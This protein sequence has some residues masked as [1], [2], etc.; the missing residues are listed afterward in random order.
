MSAVGPM[1]QRITF[2]RKT[3][4]PNSAGDAVPAFADV[5]TVWAEAIPLRG[6]ALFV[7]NQEQHQVDIR[8]RIW[9]RSGLDEA[10]R[11]V[12]QG[13]HYDVTTII[14]GTGK[15]ADRLEIMAVTGVKDGR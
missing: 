15:Y 7:A 3:T 9:D 11:I 12:W 1:D 13:R 2:Q 6:Q 10:M 4:Q 14:P 8:F 5:C